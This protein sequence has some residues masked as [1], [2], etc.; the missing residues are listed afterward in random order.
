MYAGPLKA[1]RLSKLDVSGSRVWTRTVQP[2]SFTNKMAAIMAVQASQGSTNPTVEDIDGTDQTLETSAKNCDTEG[3]DLVRGEGVVFGS[4]GTSFNHLQSDLKSRFTSGV[5]YNR[6]SVS[7]VMQS[8]RSDVE[9]S[10][11][12]QNTSGSSITVQEAGL[13]ALGVDD[14]AAIRELL[15]ARDVLSTAVK[16]ADGESIKGTYVFRYE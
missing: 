8:S 9:H 15:V 10:R 11:T 2:D 3:D 14:T 1:L 12:M 16:L 5:S 6:G 7:L 4:S 13:V